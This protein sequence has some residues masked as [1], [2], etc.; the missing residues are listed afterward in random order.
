MLVK[1]KK[2]LKKIVVKKI[3]SMKIYITYNGGLG[4]CKLLLYS[5]AQLSYAGAYA[6]LSNA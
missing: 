5:L 4:G 3:S 6:E 2:W 1:K